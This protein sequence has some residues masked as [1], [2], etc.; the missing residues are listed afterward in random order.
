MSED[1][2]LPEGEGEL[3]C[4]C[5]KLSLPL[6][7]KGLLPR[8]KD[9]WLGLRRDEGEE[10]DGEYE[11]RPERGD[12][13]G[14][15]WPNMSD[16]KFGSTLS[17]GSCPG[18]PESKESRCCK[19]T[20]TVNSSGHTCQR[21]SSNRGFLI[22]KKPRTLRWSQSYFVTKTLALNGTRSRHGFCLPDS[23]HKRL[24]H[25]LRSVQANIHGVACIN[26]HR[27]SQKFCYNYKLL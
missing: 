15:A 17:V 25:L 9:G 26:L 19:S 7:P 18:S 21:I 4:G 27:V 1:R 8:L 5:E 22:A 16:A 24:P 10:N 20:T 13:N 11:G 6:S 2:E 12:R 3:I 23:G 14:D